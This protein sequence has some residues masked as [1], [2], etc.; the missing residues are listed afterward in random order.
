MPALAKAEDIELSD[1]QLE[2]V[3]GGCGT[4]TP[5]LCPKATITTL[6]AQFVFLQTKPT[7]R[8]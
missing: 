3:S 7:A 5:V 8:V 6:D 1:E 4:Q 2:A